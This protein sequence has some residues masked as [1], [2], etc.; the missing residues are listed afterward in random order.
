MADSDTPNYYEL[1]GVSRDADKDTITK[2]YRKLA[3]VSHPDAGGNSGMFRLLRVA[4]ET[5][6]DDARRR[7][8][9]ASLDS[10]GGRGPGSGNGGGGGGG[11]TRAGNTRTENTTG[12][13]SGPRWQHTEDV[14]Y[15]NATT[16]AP[17]PGW[18]QTGD[19]WFDDMAAGQRF[20]QQQA[21]GAAGG[22]AVDPQQLT[23]LSHVDQERPVVVE[24]PYDVGRLPALVAA[25]VFAAVGIT[26]TVTHITGVP[27]LAVG[28]MAIV[29]NYLRSAHRLP[30]TRYVGF[31]A[32]ASV[33]CTIIYMINAVP[34][35]TKYVGYALILSLGAAVL[36]A[37]RLGKSARLNRLA[38]ADSIQLRE[39]GE[40]GAGHYGD[41]DQ[42]FGDRVGADAL[43]SLTVIP[44]VRVFHG[45][46]G[47]GG[48]GAVSHAVVCGRRVALI[49]SVYWEP[50][51]YAWTPHGALGRDGQYVAGDGGGLQTEVRAYQQALGRGVD[52]RGFMLVASQRATVSGGSASAGLV[53]GDPQSV[54][55]Q[56]G[57]WFLDGGSLYRVDRDLLVKMYGYR[58]DA[59][60][61]AA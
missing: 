30:V 48:G 11:S 2:A 28:A 15:E 1:L 40:P 39:Y 52:V 26:A 34:V 45:L 29:G 24:P 3:R 33:V 9:D 56:V 18:Q 36:L 46:A 14:R 58:A 23:W 41:S 50:G 35:F 51:A 53:L 16:G 10:P 43:L 25:G 57:D 27:P 8:Y 4:F 60:K 21:G 42:R 20:P 13:G 54:V 31:A 38:P 61:D 55:Q 5:L 19:V 32:A 59:K 47:L 22:L 6:T 7:S 17:W 12:G 37:Q 49:E 44:G